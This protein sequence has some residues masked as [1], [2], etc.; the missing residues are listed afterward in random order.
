MVNTVNY[1]RY[2]G[3][4]IPSQNLKHNQLVMLLNIINGKVKLQNV[5]T[6]QSQYVSVELFDKYFK[7]VSNKYYWWKG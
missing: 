4:D 6:N 7:E 5:R 2:I 1:F 3:K